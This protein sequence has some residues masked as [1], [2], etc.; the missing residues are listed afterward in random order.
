VALI[1]AG[2]YHATWYPSYF[3]ILRAQGVDIVGVHDPDAAVATRLARRFGG[4]PFSDYEQLVSR[5]RPDFA[6]ALGRHVDMPPVFRYLVDAGVPFLMEKPWAVD[7]ATLASLVKLAE[8]RHAWVAAPFP[9]RYSYWA[10]VARRMLQRG[11]TGKVSHIVYRMVRPGVQRYID[12]GCA[13]MLRKAE[14]GGGVLLNLGCHGFDLC[15]FITGEEAEVISAVTSHSLFGL[16]VEDYAFVTLRTPSGVI[17]HNE[18][19]YTYPEAGGADDERKLAGEKA[20][21]IGTESG[22][23]IVGPGRDEVIEQPPG[24]VGL[25]PRAVIE[26][27]D[28]L[29]RGEPPP[30]GPREAYRAIAPIFTAYSL[31]GEPAAP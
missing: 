9:M 29:G 26:C 3:N 10:E 22:L 4:E 21:L 25:W 17:F 16:D 11:E 23:R 5:T 2:H 13:W 6:V 31:A 18:V 28:A 14:A 8:D 15:N 12:Q 20:L 24:Y 1:G 27:L 7:A 19:G 30:V